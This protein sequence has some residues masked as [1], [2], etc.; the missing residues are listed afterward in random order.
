[1]YESFDSFLQNVITEYYERSGKK[2]RSRFVALLIASGEIAP[3]AADAFRKAPARN[4]AA[5][6]AAA[7]ALRVG[8]RFA[9]SGP[10][11]VLVSG[12]TLASML[13]YLFKHQGVVIRQVRTFRDAIHETRAE[14]DRIQ[15]R[16]G[17][18]V[19]DTHDRELMIDGLMQRLLKDLDERAA[20]AE[21][22]AP[23]DDATDVEVVDATDTEE[24]PA[25]PAEGEGGAERG[26]EDEPEA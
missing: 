22:E 10:F 20:K 26:S 2:H 14:F 21:A 8:L 19:Y 18:G 24:D 3:V 4:L 7:G 23:D 11:A 15:G 17:D 9:L 16:H 6:A 1:M 25:E 5:S 13:A 12:L